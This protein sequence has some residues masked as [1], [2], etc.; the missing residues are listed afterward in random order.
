MNEHITFDQTSKQAYDVL[1]PRTKAS[2]FPNSRDKPNKKATNKIK[3]LSKVPPSIAKTIKK[4]TQPTQKKG[5][6]EHGNDTRH[7]KTDIKK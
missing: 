6:F 7:Y 3:R 1:P 5:Y 2:N 4:Y